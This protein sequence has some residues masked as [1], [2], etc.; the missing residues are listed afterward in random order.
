MHPQRLAL[1]GERFLWAYHAELVALGIGHDCPGFLAC[2]PDVDPAGPERKEAL[3]LLIAILCAAG[4]VEVHPVLDRLRVGY[5]HEAHADG[6][7]FVSPD[8]D[9]PLALGQNLPAEH[10]RPEPASP[11][12]S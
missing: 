11:G 4:E 10:L 7:V 5:R 8:D 1:P 12:R 9:L 2:L 3:Y 6:R